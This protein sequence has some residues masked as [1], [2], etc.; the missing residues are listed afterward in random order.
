LISII[1]QE[2]N[3]NAIVKRSDVNFNGDG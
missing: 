3:V 2:T 1:L